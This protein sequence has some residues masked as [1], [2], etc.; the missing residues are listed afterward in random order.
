MDEAGKKAARPRGRLRRLA[1]S[2][3]F[4]VPLGLAAVAL[5]G[6]A[7][8]SLGRWVRYGRSGH[9]ARESPVPEAAPIWASFRAAEKGDVDA[10]L[11]CFTG[12][13][14]AEADAELE[15]VGQQ[16]FAER[17]VAESAP[18]ALLT[19]KPLGQGDGRPGFRIFVG[20][21][22][23]VA[24]FD[25]HTAQDGGEWKICSKVSRGQRP[26]SAAE[27]DDARPPGQEGESE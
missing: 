18:G 22:D 4:Q 17:L 24:I 8:L 19:M 23:Q 21:G 9:A 11:A 27:A 6:V 1:S 10:Y 5:A 3:W 15:R 20:R 25:Y 14:R 26:L 13:A 2:L 16:A 7:G 12:E